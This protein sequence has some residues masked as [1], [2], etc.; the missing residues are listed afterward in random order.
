[1]INEQRE[2]IAEDL[3]IGAAAI[4]KELGVTPIKVYHL[5]R[6]KRLP[7]GHIGKNLIASRRQLQRAITQM[8]GTT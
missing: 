6:L 2:R 5:A 7:I 4:A 8:T 1:M 3:L